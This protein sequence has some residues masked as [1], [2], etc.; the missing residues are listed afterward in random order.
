MRI[1]LKD[2]AEKLGVTK[3]AVSL[4]LRDHPRISG[5]L[6]RR[7]KQAADELGYRPDAF[8]AR[9]SSYRVSKGG[10]RA[11]GVIAWLNHW[12]EPKQLRGYREFEFYWRG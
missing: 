4:A 1:T 2:I 6:R 3:A 9:L 8:L 7:A 12:A 10:A 11:E 5:D